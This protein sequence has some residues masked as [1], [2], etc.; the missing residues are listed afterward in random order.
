MPKGSSRHHLGNEERS[1]AE[2]VERRA[3]YPDREFDR[4][5]LDDTAMLPPGRRPAAV[6]AGLAGAAWTAG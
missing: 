2:L 4:F 1:G 5:L 6:P 3:A